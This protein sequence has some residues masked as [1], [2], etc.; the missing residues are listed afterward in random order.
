MITTTCR[1]REFFIDNLLVRIHFIIVMI[2]WTGLAP[3]DHL[4]EPFRR[5]LFWPESET[6]ALRQGC[7]GG[8]R[9]L[10]WGRGCGGGAR[11]AGRG[12]GRVAG[13]GQR[14]GGGGGG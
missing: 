8:L 5:E 1:E 13:R 10:V 12:A 9:R 7:R 6:L 3:W 4:H 11:G 14:V 2:K